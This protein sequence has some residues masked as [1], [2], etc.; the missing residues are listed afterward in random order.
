[1]IST[2]SGRNSRLGM[3]WPLTAAI[4]KPKAQI[5]QWRSTPGLD[6]APCKLNV[7]LQPVRPHRRLRD[8]GR[9]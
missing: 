6:Y 2:I 5:N 3:L 1:M 9:D 4:A 8:A 7:L